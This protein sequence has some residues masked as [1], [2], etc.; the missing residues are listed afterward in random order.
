MWAEPM[1]PQNAGK[2]PDLVLVVGGDP[3]TGQRGRVRRGKGDTARN[4]A[5]GVQPQVGRA[6]NDPAFVGR[7]LLFFKKV[8][9]VNRVWIKQQQQQ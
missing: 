5:Q 8:K 9:K 6:C 1:A 4:P 3:H 7:G 2:Q